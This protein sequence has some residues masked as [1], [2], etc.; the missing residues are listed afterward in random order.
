MTNQRSVAS[1][2]TSLLK[3]YVKLRDH[4]CGIT[5]GIRVIAFRNADHMIRSREQL[6][7]K[8]TSDDASRVHVQDKML[9]DQ[10]LEKTDN[11]RWLLELATSVPWEIYMCLLYAE[12][13]HYRTVSHKH[14]ALVYTPLADHLALHP[15]L[16]QSLRE[17]RDSL[18]HPLKET[19]HKENL[20]RFT[21]DAGRAGPGPV[22]AL[23][24]MENL[25]DDYLEWF[26]TSLIESLADEISKQ[27][28]EEIFEFNRRHVNR[29]TN[30]I[31][32]SESLEAR[33]ATKKLLDEWQESDESL[34]LNVQPDF[35][36]S[37]SQR[38]RVSQW[39]KVMDTLALPLPERPYLKS[40]ASVQTPIHRELSSF[41]PA[42][43]TEGQPAWTGQALPE[44]LQRNRSGF[45]GLLV[46]SVMIYNEPYTAIVADFEAKS[47]N[48]FRAD[49]LNSDEM[50][51]EFVQGLL[52][53]ETREDIRRAEMRTS[54]STVAMA[55]LAV[56]GGDKMYH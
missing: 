36:L 20:Q 4:R 21:E 43:P 29:L 44:Y 18:L 38:R 14:K 3:Y 24:T 32:N 48:K 27:P 55:L 50:V 41:I 19:T 46:R 33:I 47:P 23:V 40:R 10:G 16:V 45:I 25:I 9:E 17:V 28:D 52:P 53:L 34:A 54:P 7:V 15:H 11:N 49:I 39:E 37:T 42:P 12:I 2:D 51:R 26:R 8:D 56:K 1:I 5:E 22:P 13:E 31:A 6:G 35:V 30:M